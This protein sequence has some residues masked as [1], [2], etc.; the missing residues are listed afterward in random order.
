MITFDVT[1]NGKRPGLVLLRK[2]I[3]KMSKKQLPLFKKKVLRATGVRTKRYIVQNI[4][5]SIPKFKNRLVR[6]VHRR[7][8]KN[9]VTVWVAHGGAAALEF[10]YGPHFIHRNMISGGGYKV[11]DWMDA[12]GMQGRN[13]VMVGTGKTARGSFFVSRAYDRIVKEF[14][15]IMKENLKEFKR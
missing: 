15:S 8:M 3:S 2:Q 6:S 9:A 4:N 13:Y 7:T 5:S 10:G 14:P 12:K 11:G 1:F